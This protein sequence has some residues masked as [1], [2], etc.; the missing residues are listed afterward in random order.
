MSTALYEVQFS[1]HT[2]KDPH[3]HTHTHSSACCFT[4]KDLAH[5]DPTGE[6]DF[7]WF[8]LVW[9][10][11]WFFQT[12]A[13]FFFGKRDPVCFNG[14]PSLFPFFLSAAPRSCRCHVDVGDA[15]VFVWHAVVLRVSCCGMFRC[16]KVIV[17]CFF[18]FSFSFSI[19][20][21]RLLS[22]CWT[23]VWV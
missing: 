5:V 23:A 7:T 17:F 13:S 14:A 18:F 9:A 20:L 4:V 2:H 15:L 22:L 12:A 3:R 16:I 10:A 11:R 1:L 21:S 19:A 6:P 8:R